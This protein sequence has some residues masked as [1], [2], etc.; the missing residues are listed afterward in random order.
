MKRS[1]RILVMVM[2]F[3]LVSAI[4]I[5]KRASA[6]T[7]DSDLDG[8]EDS[9][10]K[11]PFDYDNDGM[12]DIWEKRNSLRYDVS[13]ADEDP[14]ND[15]I[16]NI[17]EYKGGT[18]PMVSDKRAGGTAPELFTPV[19]R[20][21]AR[22]LIWAGT[23]LFIFALLA[24]IIFLIYRN[25][26]FN[27]L[28]SMKNAGVE[29]PEEKRTAG[30]YPASRHYNLPPAYRRRAVLQPQQRIR[31]YPGRDFAGKT[32]GH[33]PARG[34]TAFSGYAPRRG[35]P[36]Q[37]GYTATKAY[38]PTKTNKKAGQE[39]MN[40]QEKKAD[41]LQ[42]KG[43]GEEKKQEAYNAQ[44]GYMNQKENQKAGQAEG[45]SKEKKGD[46][47]EMLSRYTNGKN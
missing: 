3:L 47:F 36:P 44:E 13:D 20:T 29:H 25:K 43:F 28:R 6:E 40:M 46:I 1:D 15:G 30:T 27:I 10:D 39:K 7:K 5:V 31:Q 41:V 8:I 33:A 37:R 21:M 45:A 32:G 14:D 38:A 4:F 2:L 16:K 17:D 35:Y 22:G 42:K 23:A 19:E 12:P 24:F 34:Y 9:K 18:N 11:F 26:I